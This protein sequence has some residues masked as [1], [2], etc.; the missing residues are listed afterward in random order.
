MPEKWLPR[1]LVLLSRRTTSTLSHVSKLSV[2]RRCDDSSASRRFESVRPEKTTPH[3]KVAS[4][5]LR[6]KTVI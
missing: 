4:G 3:P 6:S 5:G 2:M 1:M